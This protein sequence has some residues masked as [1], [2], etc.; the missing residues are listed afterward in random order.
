MHTVILAGGKGTRL[1]PYTTT[2]PKPLVPVGDEPI[3]S[4]VIRQLAAAGCDRITLAVCHMAELI[5]SFFGNGSKFGL[6]I[7]YSVEPFPL[8]TVGPVRL[9]EDLPKHF[10]VMNG[11]ILTDLPYGDLFT[12]HLNSGSDLTVASYRRDVP[13]D[14]G[15]LQLDHAAN[16][17][18]GFS[19]K[20]VHHVNVSMGVYAFSRK[21]LERIPEKRQFGFDDLMLG[22]LNERLPINTFPY[23]GYWLDLGRPDDYDKANDDIQNSPALRTSAAKVSAAGHAPYLGNGRR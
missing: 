3:L 14:F 12:S 17:V 22:M 1:K 21:L 10:L 2:L 16:R 11:D 4:I 13:I 8:G 7:D 9:V 6:R 20:P 5:M 18:T 19:E 23:Q 15:V